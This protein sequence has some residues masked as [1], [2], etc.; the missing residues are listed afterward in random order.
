MM[1]DP[2]RRA[3]LQKTMP[4]L[5]EDQLPADEDEREIC[6]RLFELVA[7]TGNAAYVK[8]MNEDLAIRFCR[9]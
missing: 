5:E 9:G 3:R 8:E 7:K 4:A 2:T 6:G 1:K